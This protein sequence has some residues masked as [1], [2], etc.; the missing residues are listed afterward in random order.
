MSAILASNDGCIDARALPAVVTWSSDTEVLT[1]AFHDPHTGCEPTERHPRSYLDVAG[2][3]VTLRADSLLEHCGRYQFDVE[4]RGDASS[5]VSLVVD[6]GETCIE[7]EPAS[8]YS[9]HKTLD[10]TTHTVV[11]DHKHAEMPAIPQIPEPSTFLLLL[12]GLCLTCVMR[13]L[14]TVSHGDSQ[15]ERARHAAHAR[16]AQRTHDTL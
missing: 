8:F 1:G 4:Q 14:Y 12:C 13:S 6:F 3:L 15:N 9:M 2:E 10:T 5:M 11:A 16:R 7:A